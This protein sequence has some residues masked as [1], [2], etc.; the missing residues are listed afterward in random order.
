V[1]CYDSNREAIVA[2]R[3]DREV[4]LDS[5]DRVT[6]LFDPFLDRRNAF[7]VGR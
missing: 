4:T 1:S 7:I 5:G 3:L 2:T 6:L